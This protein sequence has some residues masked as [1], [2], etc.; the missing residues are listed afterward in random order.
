MPLKIIEN[1]TGEQIKIKPI[2]SKKGKPS[3]ILFESKIPKNV[4]TVSFPANPADGAKPSGKIVHRLPKTSSKIPTPPK[5]PLKSLTPKKTSHEKAHSTIL[6]KEE[7]KKHPKINKKKKK[8]L[9]PLFKKKKLKPEKKERVA[10]IAPVAYDK[11]IDDEFDSFADPTK[12]KSKAELEEHALLKPQA[13]INNFQKLLGEKDK[14]DGDFES[15]SSGE[16]ESSGS[17]SEEYESETDEEEEE[18]HS[19]VQFVNP[20]KKKPPVVMTKNQLVWKKTILQ[21]KIKRLAK[22]LHIQ[23]DIPMNASL[24]ELQEIYYSHAYERESTRSVRTYRNIMVFMCMLTEGAASYANNPNFDLNGWSMD[25]F[26]NKDTYDEHLFDIYDEYGAKMKTN[27]FMALGGE[28]ASSAGM[29][30]LSKKFMNNP[31]MKHLFGSG[32]PMN[33]QNK[34]PQAGTPQANPLAGLSALL[35]GPQGANLMSNVMNM[36]AGN[37]GPMA[38]SRQT[39]PQ[40]RQTDIPTNNDQSTFVSQRPPQTNSTPISQFNRPRHNRQNIEPTKRATP[41]FDDMEPPAEIKTND[42]LLNALR[43]EEDQTTKSKVTAPVKNIPK[44][45]TF[46]RRRRRPLAENNKQN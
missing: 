1:T 12:K 4:S 19:K 36:F 32:G 25:V 21:G 46:T 39:A 11:K 40:N 41:T 16:Y 22:N 42:D 17:S 24:E 34:P 2:R 31:A 5:K 27:P 14:S 28:L 9:R 10:E 33:T 45:G 30:S 23:V 38:Q 20:D 43:K 7:Q 29:F 35:Q 13:N 18:D 44:R 6:E 15:E 37:K 3:N 8:L 26:M